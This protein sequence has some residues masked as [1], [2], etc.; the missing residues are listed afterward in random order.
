[1]VAVSDGA[2]MFWALNEVAN[3]I[4]AVS[5]LAVMSPTD[6]AVALM[7]GT[8]SKVADTLVALSSATHK[9][10]HFASV[11]SSVVAV[12]VC[13]WICVLC[14]VV[15]VMFARLAE[16][17]LSCVTLHEVAVSCGAV[18][19]PCSCSAVTLTAVSVPAVMVCALNAGAVSRVVAVI[20]V[21]LKGPD[22]VMDDALTAPTVMLC[23]DTESADIAP[24]MIAVSVSKL[25][26]LMTAACT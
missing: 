13:A 8:V 11:H 1:M 26:A 6:R 5:L 14:S 17:A 2:V 19:E 25:V 21:A 9:L 23:A 18:S 24:R 10:E 7:L 22:E 16:S 12:I 3:T 20:S 4:G 15:D